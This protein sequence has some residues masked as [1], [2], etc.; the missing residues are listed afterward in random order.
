MC[1]MGSE[2]NDSLAVHTCRFVKATDMLADPVN[3]G[4]LS[5]S[6]MYVSKVHLLCA[7]ACVLHTN[8]MSI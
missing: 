6:C 7:C 3:P 2:C 8:Y 4:V 1:M 5:N